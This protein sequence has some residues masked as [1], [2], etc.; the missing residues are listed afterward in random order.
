MDPTGKKN[1]EQDSNS[2]C[3]DLQE[4]EATESEEKRRKKK[5]YKHKDKYNKDDDVILEKE[6]FNRLNAKKLTQE[7]VKEHKKKVKAGQTP[8]ER[9]ASTSNP[10][11]SIKITTKIPMKAWTS[12]K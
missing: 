5:Q 8:K 10:P 7:R 2:C 12:T 11:A 3:E 4:E 1:P 9:W 6:V